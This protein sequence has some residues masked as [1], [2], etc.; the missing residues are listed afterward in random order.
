MLWRLVTTESVET[1]EQIE[2]V[3]DCYRTRWLIEEFFKAIKTGCGYE[4][5]QLE[6]I[7]SLLRMLA[8]ESAIAWRMLLLRWL[9]R[10]EADSPVEQVLTPIQSE[11]LMAWMKARK[12]RIPPNLTIGFVLYEI[13][14]MGGHI[15]HNGPPGWLVMRRGFDELLSMEYGWVMAIASLSDK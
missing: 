1:Q 7:N 8:I 15:K 2:K 6:D 14:A 11:V 4:R 10:Y 9:S 3:I 12:R 5:H 13:A